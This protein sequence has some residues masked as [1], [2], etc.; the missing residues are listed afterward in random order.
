[1]KLAPSILSS[2]FLKLEEEIKKIEVEGVAFLHLDI[3]DGVFVPN[4]T[5]GSNVVKQIRKITKL[6]LD[7]HLMIVNPEK[8]V[9]D[10]INAGVDVLTIH[11]EATNHPE[12]LLRYIKSKGIKAGISINPATDINSLKYL[13]GAFDLILVMTVN[14]GFGGQKL[15]PSTL[16]KIKFLKKEKES[17][18]LDFIIEVDGGVNKENISE[19]V[20][21]G[22]EVVVAG[23]AVFGKGNVSDNIK[24]LLK[25]G[26]K[27]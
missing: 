9:D 8:H 21:A 27:L 4:I 6:P 15:I 1:M 16:E 5:I 2:N 23:N 25:E 11:L 20:K 12:R 24:E 13:Y 7:A 26:N 17:K 22:A 10:F 19:Y 3:M 14:P 18:K